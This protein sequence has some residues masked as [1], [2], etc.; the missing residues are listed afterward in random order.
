MA[1]FVASIRRDKAPVRGRAVG[2]NGNGNGTPK[3]PSISQS[4][5]PI[6]RKGKH[7]DIVTELLSQLEGLDEGRALKIP[8]TELPDTKANI[9]AALSRAC[10]QKSI[11]IAT[12]SDDQFLYLWKPADDETTQL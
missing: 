9:R 5:L 2:T 3:F 1:P 10:K 6:G 12:S 8:I 4:D 7:F 11:D